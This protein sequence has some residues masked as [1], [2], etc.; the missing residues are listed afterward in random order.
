M[1]IRWDL[2][3]LCQDIF[4]EFQESTDSGKNSSEMGNNFLGELFWQWQTTQRSQSDKTVRRIEICQ[5]AP[6][7]FPPTENFELDPLAQC[8]WME[9]A[10]LHR[11][12][13]LYTILTHN[14]QLIYVT[15]KLLGLKKHR[16]FKVKRRAKSIF[17][18]II[19]EVQNAHQI[20]SFEHKVVKVKQKFIFMS[21]TY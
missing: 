1:W 16:T 12:V 5:P 19:F 8:I 21:W 10:Y 9:T 13:H 14:I 20:N 2:F 11:Y 15:R 4:I 17:Y 3:H 7:N 6:R 18:I